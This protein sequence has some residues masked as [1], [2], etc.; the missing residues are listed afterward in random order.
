MNNTTEKPAAL[1]AFTEEQKKAAVHKE[2]PMLVIAGP[3]SGKTTVLTHRIRYLTSEYQVPGSR[4]LVITFSSA[5]AR[6]ME[7]RYQKLCPPGEKN[8][9]VCF[10]TFHSVF[11]HVLCKYGV[12]R[13][14][15]KLADRRM[16]LA[17]LQQAA[18][19]CFRK[20]AAAFPGINLTTDAY[21]LLLGEIGRLK[22]GLPVRNELAERLLP[23][24]NRCLGRQDLLD[25]DDMLLDFLDLLRNNPAVLSALRKS[26]EY[27]MID[28]FQDINPV[29]FAAVQLLAAPR[30]NLFAVGDDDQSIYSFR[31][32]DPDIMLSFPQLYP[33]AEIISLTR[34]FRSSG[35][36]VFRSACLISRNKKRFPKHL[37]T[38]NPK[39]PEPEIRCFAS[40]DDEAEFIRISLEGQPPDLT[41]GILYR[42]H[43]EGKHFLRF[44]SSN[45]CC[46]T[47]HA[48]KGLEF[49]IV[50]IVSASDRKENGMPGIAEEERRMFYV[51][52][53]RAR[54]ELHISYTK[55]SYNH[56]NKCSR[57]IQE[58]RRRGGFPWII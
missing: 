40:S 4:I 23:A 45:V 35:S 34:N 25:F 17:V 8:P 18:E 27:I 30:D 57:F 42:T 43:K 47:F 29:Q 37:Y 24:Y 22:N 1:P 32:S 39:G 58:S 54:K 50:Y 2:G 41:V 51:A 16:Q 20:E 36:V 10:G 3:G 31:G 55:Y 44:A 49:D 33:K 21:E 9:G 13:Q 52:M 15:K 6:E 28:E 46:M 48:S 53:T 7:Q 19:E 26:W 38:E 14:T 5:A 12:Y 56:K 11:Y